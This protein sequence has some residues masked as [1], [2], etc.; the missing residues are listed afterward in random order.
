M[1]LHER[2]MPLL[3]QFQQSLG[4]LGSIYKTS[5]LNKVNY[6]IGNKKDLAKLILFLEKYP[7]LTQKA[8]DLFFFKQ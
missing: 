2:D 3:L 6:I 8:A 5:T 4:E 1:G 7:L